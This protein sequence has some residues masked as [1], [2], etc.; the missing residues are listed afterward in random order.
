MTYTSVNQQYP[1]PTNFD[2]LSGTPGI[3]AV[4]T[5][6]NF[7]LQPGGMGYTYTT[8]NTALTS[9]G[10]VVVDGE[11]T[12]SGTGVVSGNGWGVRG[13]TTVSGTV[14]GGAFIFGA[15]AKMVLSGTQNHA[16]S[17]LAAFFCKLDASAGTYTAGQLSSAWFDMGATAPSGGWA[18]GAQANVIR[19][20]N[21]TGS[22][23]NALIYGYGKATFGLDLSD[24]SSTW[25]YTSGTAQTAAGGIKISA[26]STT[27]YIQLYSG[28]PQ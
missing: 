13:L 16:D 6:G 14:T 23:V 2:A 24:N 19:V 7:V 26:N 28:A 21:T 27:R 8:T 22:N 5:P 11:L 17:R 9:T 3:A 12:I 10:T 4:Q 18:T 1:W 25:I 15:Y 20:Q